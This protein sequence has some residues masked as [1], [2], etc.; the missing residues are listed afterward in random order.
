VD[1]RELSR[2]SC[3]QID[4]IRCA[5]WFFSFLCFCVCKH[6]LLRRL[7]RLLP[8]SSSLTSSADDRGNVRLF[9]AYTRCTFRQVR[10]SVRENSY[11]IKYRKGFL[12]VWCWSRPSRSYNHLDGFHLSL[13]ISTL[14]ALDRESPPVAISMQLPRIYALIYLSHTLGNGI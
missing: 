2:C 12:S 4:R 11:T 7:C 5:S 6:G 3:L 8:S 1:F 13:S 9:D 14:L 10:L